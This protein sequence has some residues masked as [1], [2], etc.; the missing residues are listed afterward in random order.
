MNFACNFGPREQIPM[1][2][3]T[4]RS[5]EAGAGAM[6]KVKPN[7]K[8]HGFECEICSERFSTAK[9]A[10]VHMTEDHLKGVRI[11]VFQKNTFSK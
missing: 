3:R 8:S 5:C 7:K 9:E 6:R 10:A 11:R 1:R 4:L 2:F